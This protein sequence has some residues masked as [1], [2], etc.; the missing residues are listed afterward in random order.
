MLGEMVQFVRQLQGFCQL[1]V[2]EYSWDD[3]Q[4]FFS[5]RQGDLDELIQSHRAYLNAL[6][7]KVL[8][9]G[10]KRGAQVGRTRE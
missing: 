6:I 9:R 3:L 7:G 8:L 5:R 4:T 10:G 1:E 2:I